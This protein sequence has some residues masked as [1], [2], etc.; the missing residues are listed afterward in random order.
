MNLNHMLNTV[1]QL[2][3]LANKTKAKEAERLEAELYE[4]LKHISEDIDTHITTVKAKRKAISDAMKDHWASRRQL[5]VHFRETGQKI[6]TTSFEKVAE[7]IGY[8]VASVRNKLA[9]G[10]GRFS[11]MHDDDVATVTNLSTYK[12]AKAA[13]A[14]SDPPKGSY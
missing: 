13:H 4:Q 11:V 10:N 8:S 6:E 7:L 2:A 9:R 5:Q 1:S 14:K 12:P 3:A